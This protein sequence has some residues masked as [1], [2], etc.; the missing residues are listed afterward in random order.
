[1][2]VR[3]TEDPPPHVVRGGAGGWGGGGGY[4]GRLGPEDFT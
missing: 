4:C 2:Q 1:M 3:W